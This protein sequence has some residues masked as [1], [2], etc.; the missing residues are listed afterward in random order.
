MRT[1]HG[2]LSNFRPASSA[3]RRTGARI[4]PDVWG[5]L[6]AEV[7]KLA[8]REGIDKRDDELLT[9]L[10]LQ[11]ERRQQEL[12]LLEAQ[13]RAP[14]IR[15]KQRDQWEQFAN[16]A[17]REARRVEG[18]AAKERGKALR[19]RLKPLR[20]AEAAEKAAP[21]EAVKLKYE[22]LRAEARAKFER[23]WRP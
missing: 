23:E 17:L 6:P 7:R 2:W 22:R 14:E 15:Q 20:Q 19:Q 9:N 4:I 13:R 3:P 12:E 5:T 10:L 18:E 11:W 21:A 1:P 8:E 16:P